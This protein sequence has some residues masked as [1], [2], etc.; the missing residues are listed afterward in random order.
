[1]RI[2]VCFIWSDRDG[3][4]ELTRNCILGTITHILAMNLGQH[5]TQCTF[6]QRFRMNYDAP[7]IV[8][9]TQM[10]SFLHHLSRILHR[11]ID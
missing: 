11:S 9:I 8:E 2:V 5:E 7:P 6:C 3:T 4:V 10:L 1:M